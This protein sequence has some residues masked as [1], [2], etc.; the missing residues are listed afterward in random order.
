MEFKQ[1]KRQFFVIN[2]EKINFSEAQFFAHQKL[3]SKIEKW[4][5]ELW[6]FIIEWFK[7]DK[8]ILVKTS[9][10]TGTPKSILL[11]KSLM[12]LS[13]EKTI[14]FLKLHE[15]QNALLCLPVE[16]IAGKMMIVRAII[17]G[18]NIFSVPPQIKLNIPDKEIH[19][20]AF[21]P[22]QLESLIEQNFDFNKI[23]NTIIGGAAISHSLNQKIALLPNSIYATYGMTETITH[24]ALQKLNGEDKKEYF[25][26]FD[27]IKISVDEREC[28]KISS[29]FSAEPLQTNDIISFHST[30]S[31]TWLGRADNVINSG[32]LKLFPE[33]IEKTIS[34][35]IRYPFFVY[36]IADKNLGQ[37]LVLFIE[38]TINKNFISEIKPLLKKAL[39]KNQL[40]KQIAI[41]EQFE[42]TENQ[43]IMRNKT[44]NSTKNQTVIT[45]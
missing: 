8:H 40:P 41:L 9:G 14:S 22:A 34:E 37:K 39:S 2:N 18:L 32:G 1:Y 31:F 25:T 5:A 7:P 36:G 33:Q 29:P 4:E 19:F 38:M 21:I 11:E 10:S 24:I 15:N 30:N 27:H 45:F 42:Y 20:A 23:K 16:F 17:S 28:L 6:K 26:T 3:K 44:A 35:F 12:I 13:A 43:K